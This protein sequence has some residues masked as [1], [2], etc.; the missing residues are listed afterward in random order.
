MSQ[1]GNI[2]IVIGRLTCNLNFPLAKIESKCILTALQFKQYFFKKMENFRYEGKSWEA[3]TFMCSFN[4]SG[5]SFHNLSG[6]S[7]AWLAR[8]PWEQEAVG[9]NPT[10]P[11]SSIK[12]L[13][14]R[15]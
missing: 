4:S 3:G 8:L 6:R 5:F 15:L 7:A 13:W 9:S 14:L 2:G 10:A 12:H 11:T 1:I